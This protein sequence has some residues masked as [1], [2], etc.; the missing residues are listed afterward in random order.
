[1]DLKEIDPVTCTGLVRLKV[2][3]V[4]VEGSCSSLFGGFFFFFFS[5]LSYLFFSI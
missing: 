2:E 1:M 5:P 4:A 3:Q